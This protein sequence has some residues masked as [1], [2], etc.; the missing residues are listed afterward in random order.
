MLN[1]DQDKKFSKLTKKLIL[2]FLRIYKVQTFKLTLKK[3][4]SDFKIKK[5]IIYIM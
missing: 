3:S 2:T 5:S 4:H 1:R